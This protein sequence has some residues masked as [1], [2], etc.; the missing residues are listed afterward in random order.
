MAR[1]KSRRSKPPARI[2]DSNLLQGALSELRTPFKQRHDAI[3][4]KSSKRGKKKR[5]EH[6]ERASAYDAKT[7]RDEDRES[8]RPRWFLKSKRNSASSSLWKRKANQYLPPTCRRDADFLRSSNAP[9][10]HRPRLVQN[11]RATRENEPVERYLPTY[12]GEWLGRAVVAP[13]KRRR[14]VLDLYY[15]TALQ[16]HSPGEAQYNRRRL[17]NEKR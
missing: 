14:R 15:E 10:I 3:I 17:K 8:R 16:T 13:V 4:K 5:E 7:E 2:A 11:L 9:D 12:V 1:A 6:V